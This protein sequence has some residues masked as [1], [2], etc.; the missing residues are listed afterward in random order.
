MMCFSRIGV[1]GEVYL[2]YNTVEHLMRGASGKSGAT[3]EACF[4]QLVEKSQ[5][6]GLFF[7]LTFC[8]DVVTSGNFVMHITPTI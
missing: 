3:P 8:G 2:V 5:P 6:A 1:L 4:D 7:V